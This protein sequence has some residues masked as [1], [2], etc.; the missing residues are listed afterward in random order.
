MYI[1]LLSHVYVCLYTN[2]VCNA[3][4]IIIY[5][6]LQITYAELQLSTELK[7]RDPTNHDTAVTYSQIA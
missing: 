4:I 2:S 6:L 7:E 1:I 3:T 5:M